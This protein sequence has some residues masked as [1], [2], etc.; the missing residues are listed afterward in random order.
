[1]NSE[2]GMDK[3]ILFDEFAPLTGLDCTCMELS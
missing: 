3:G 2:L 1:M